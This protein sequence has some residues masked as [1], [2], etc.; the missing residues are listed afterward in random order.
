MENIKGVVE[1]FKEK[2]I[3]IIGDVMLD[4]FT[5]GEVTRI[6]PEAPVPVLRKTDEKFFPG[7]A[8]NVAYNISSLG[9]RAILCGVV[10][11]DSDKDI[12][13]KILE[14]RNIETSMVLT[15]PARPTTTKHRFLSGS[16]QILRLD[17]EVV[18]NL[19]VEIE[20]RL[21]KFIKRAIKSCDG[22]VLSDYAKG[23]FS[24]NLTQ[25]IIEMVKKQGKKV[26]ADI[27]PVNKELFMGVDLVKPNL[28]E[29][30][31]MTGQV[32]LQEIGEALVGYF[33]SDVIV[34][35]GAEG[36]SIFTLSKAFN[37]PTKKIKV[38]DVS[39]AGD[40]VMAVVALG[41]VSGL[42]L[43]DVAT[44]ANYAG[45]IVVQKPGTATVTAEELLSPFQGEHHL[46]E[47]YTVPKI[48]GFEKWLENNEKY[49][50]KLL[51]LKSGYQCSLHYH[52]IKDEMFLVTKGH[53][54]ME[55]DDK[56]LHM[57]EGNFIRIIPGTVHRF[58]GIE[59]SEILEIST[60]HME[61]DSYRIKGEES[62]RVEA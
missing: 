31:E 19:S 24:L 38:F 14:E 16:N 7:G 6:S 52:K 1:K 57:R 62:R 9:A 13:L 61:E 15:V 51:A 42:S 60:H 47:V 4:K 25:K 33:K 27:K 41:L 37:V 55:V 30:R 2:R 21:L 29:A 5:H 45:G 48:W 35:Q 20:Y 22:V 53:V 56:V 40:T 59:D 44:M 28:K 12:L 50:S 34:T 10:G 11:E 54:R 46:E 23:L 43:E 26:I 32:T 39:G 3:L 18:E 17:N 8:A 49:C 36:M 58:R